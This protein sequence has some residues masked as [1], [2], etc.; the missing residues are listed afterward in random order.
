MTAEGQGRPGG[1]REEDEGEVGV[2][3]QL[4][5]MYSGC[6]WDG[7]CISHGKHRA[8]EQ[9]FPFCNVVGK[10]QVESSV[11][12]PAQLVEDGL[13][14]LLQAIRVRFPSSCVPRRLARSLTLRLYANN[15]V[16]VESPLFP[17][18]RRRG[19]HIPMRR[20][21]IRSQDRVRGVV[22]LTSDVRSKLPLEFVIILE[23]VLS[24][25]P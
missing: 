13:W 2:S 24:R 14:F 1:G 8:G 20:T 17:S 11:R 10:S 15:D 19:Q 3:Y 5:E 6:V 23:G 9:W 25:R 4:R 21:V 18:R 22:T 16:L 7:V 12:A